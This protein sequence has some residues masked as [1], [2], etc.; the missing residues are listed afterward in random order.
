MQISEDE[1]RKRQRT[2]KEKAEL[3]KELGLDEELSSAASLIEDKSIRE[4]IERHDDRCSYN[5][6]PLNFLS[7]GLDEKGELLQFRTYVPGDP[8]RHCTLNRQTREMIYSKL[9]PILRELLPNK[10]LSDYEI[11]EDKKLAAMTPEEREAYLKAKEEKFKK[12]LA[13]A[14]QP[15]LKEV[16]QSSA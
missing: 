10:A 14:Q 2:L 4:T 9:P 12:Y 6:C 11:A 13:S 15:K 5:A 3:L 7:F 8:S 1:I 16:S